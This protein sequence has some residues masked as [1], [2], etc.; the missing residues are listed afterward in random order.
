MHLHIKKLG[1]NSSAAP[2]E[3]CTI[4]QEEKKPFG[5]LNNEMIIKI[6]GKLLKIHLLKTDF[7]KISSSFHLSQQ[8]T[9]GNNYLVV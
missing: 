4:N 8:V 5:S 3:S 1:S 9:K 6:F 2:R 7:K